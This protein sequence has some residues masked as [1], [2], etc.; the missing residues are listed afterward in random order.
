MKRESFNSLRS[1][2]YKQRKAAVRDNKYSTLAIYA[3][4]S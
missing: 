3:Q 1:G 2:I 4:L